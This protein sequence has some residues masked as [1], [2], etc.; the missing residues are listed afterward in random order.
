MGVT[1]HPTPGRNGER[2]FHG[3]KRSNE[4]H[5]STTDPDARL[6]RKSA[7]Q[8]AKL[9]HMAHVLM[10]NRNGLVVDTITTLATGTAE[11]EAAQAMVE[12]LPSTRRVTVAGDKNYDTRDFVAGL[13]NIGATPHVAQHTNGRRSAIDGRTTRHAGYAT[14][15]RVRKRIEEIFGWT[16][17][18]GGLRKTRHRGTAR[19]GWI[20]HLRRSRLQSG[21]AAKAA[22]RS[23]L[24]APGVRPDT[25]NPRLRTSVS[26]KT[27]AQPIVSRLK[28]QQ[29]TQNHSYFRSLLGR[30][31]GAAG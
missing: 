4:T 24:T 14:S 28:T 11:R 17:T 2:D 20:V 12:A 8:S 16:K 21:A 3:E 26:N 9:C 13:R 10:E 23:G 1:S 27:P 29:N 19:V 7:G 5:A 6:L 22:G 25:E 31:A 15:Q 18:V 30:H